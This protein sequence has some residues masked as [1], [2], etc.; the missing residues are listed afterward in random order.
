M[1]LPRI[2]ALVASLS[3]ALAAGAITPALA[4]ADPVEPAV[5]SSARDLGN[6]EVEFSVTNT[7]NV[8]TFTIDW[9]IDDEELREISGVNFPVGRTGGMH[10][11]VLAGPRWPDDVDTEG[12]NTVEKRWMRSG[13]E[14]STA[15]YTRDLKNLTDSYNPPLPNP[16]AAEHSV[17]YRIV[18]GPPGNNGELQWGDR[19]WLG[20]R[21]WKSVTVTGC[22]PVVPDPDPDED[23]DSPWTGLFDLLFGSLGS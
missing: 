8:T 17:D 4:G 23:D 21:E 12:E 19:E 18:L 3:L 20:D 14:P 5:Q 2:G 7:T 22:A 9:R 6:C 11:T 1:S 10:S 13:L 16:G 15:T